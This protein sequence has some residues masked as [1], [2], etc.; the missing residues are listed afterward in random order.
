MQ[1]PS[2]SSFCRP[3]PGSARRAGKQEGRRDVP[4]R[5]PARAAPLHATGR[6]WWWATP[7]AAAA[8]QQQQAA[9]GSRLAAAE[10]REDA[11]SYYLARSSSL[12][13]VVPDRHKLRV[14]ARRSHELLVRPL[15]RRRREGASGGRWRRA[16]LNYFIRSFFFRIDSAAVN[17]TQAHL[18]HQD[19]LRDDADD[20]RVA[21]GAEPVR[22]RDR[23]PAKSRARARAS[24]IHLHSAH[25]HRALRRRSVVRMITLWAA[26]RARYGNARTARP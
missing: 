6:R 12:F 24:T 21:H 17:S 11:T 1:D 13:A 8:G 9:A 18:L 14:L 15:Q 16:S 2:A 23:R 22:H 10:G 4:A 7:P 20:V 26:R 3:P 5:P 19:A 25:H